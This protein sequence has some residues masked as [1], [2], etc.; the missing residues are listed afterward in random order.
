[1]LIGIE[2]EKVALIF[3]YVMQQISKG[4]KST[5]ADAK[6]FF[7]SSEEIS[8]LGED[9][10]VP[11]S[12][13]QQA[14]ANMRSDYTAYTP[15][16]M[17]TT[18]AVL[19]KYLEKKTSNFDA[20]NLTRDEYFKW[21]NINQVSPLCF[22]DFFLVEQATY[23]CQ[24]YLDHNE[25]YEHDDDGLIELSARAAYYMF[26]NV[27]RKQVLNLRSNTSDLQS[28]PSLFIGFK[29]DTDLYQFLEDEIEDVSG[30]WRYDEDDEDDGD[31]EE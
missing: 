24:I 26:Q 5:F 31:E 16:S 18:V 28:N 23:I 25:T 6:D 21:S 3:L 29:T 1:M 27:F 22:L 20:G 2:D 14:L 19:L 7:V 4:N 10:I 30:I 12:L 17:S 9:V 15:N 8:D 13:Y 11:K